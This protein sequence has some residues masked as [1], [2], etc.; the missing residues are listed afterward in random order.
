MSRG[1]IRPTRVVLS[2]AALVHNLRVIQARVGARRVWPMVKANAYGHG[3]RE[4]VEALSGEPV[5]GFGVAT[6]EE[7]FALRA[8]LGAEGPRARTPIFLFAAEYGAAHADI[9]AAGLTPTLGR[10]EDVAA[11]ARAADRLGRAE[12]PVHVEVDTGMSRLGIRFDQLHALLEAL[13]AHPALRVEGVFTHFA[14][15]ESAGE[16]RFT[17]RQLWRFRAAQEAFRAAGHAPLWHAAN[18]G[19][20]FRHPEAWFDAVRPG[21]SF[22]GV[23]PSEL[24][25]VADVAVLSADGAEAPP[26]A[27]RPAL[28]LVGAVHSVRALRPGDTAGYDRTFRADRE[29]RLATVLIGYGDGLHR[30]ASGRGEA[31]VRRRRVPFVGRIS[32]DSLLLDV[33]EVPEAT[34][35]D[36]VVLVGAQ[37]TD[38]L[39]AHDL[40]RA[41]G[42]NAYEVLTSLTD[43][44]PRVLER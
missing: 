24:G 41:A 23:T 42:T 22:Y 15:S 26:L 4:V 11:F 28:S 2:G 38:A 10:V 31:L 16:D 37:G 33:T 8:M 25:N 30:A 29:A 19:A 20:V 6:A 17:E 39:S 43:R 36:E 40:A 12:A 14:A 1:T 21:L 3:V 5:A 9:L 34:T 32:M 44:I 35:G 18:S 7:G 13:R 27:L